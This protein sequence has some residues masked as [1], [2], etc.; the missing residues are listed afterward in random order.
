M[1]NQQS[2]DD[3]NMKNPKINLLVSFSCILPSKKNRRNM[4]HDVNPSKKMQKINNYNR[5]ITHKSKTNSNTLGAI[6]KIRKV[7]EYSRLSEYR[8]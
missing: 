4:L 1:D 6:K 3:N 8:T 7:Q 5:D 2:K